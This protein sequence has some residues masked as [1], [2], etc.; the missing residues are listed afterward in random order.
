MKGGP[1]LEYCGRWT[2]RS[3]PC[4]YK[5]ALSRKRGLWL[6]AMSG[7][8]LCGDITLLYCVTYFAVLATWIS[9]GDQPGVKIDTLCA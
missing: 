6:A 8:Y 1:T 4:P 7:N 2:A 3:F 5:K 9:R